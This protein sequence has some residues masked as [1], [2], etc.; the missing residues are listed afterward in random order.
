M[1]S[2]EHISNGEDYRTKEA[3]CVEK[4]VGYFSCLRAWAGGTRRRFV[5]FGAPPSAH[6]LTP[7]NN[8]H[9]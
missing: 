8:L 2:E 4:T 7:L 5:A 6:F 1:L 9:F 3:R